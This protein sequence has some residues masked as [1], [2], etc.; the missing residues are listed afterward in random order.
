MGVY[1]NINATHSPGVAPEVTKYFERT[2]LEETEANLVHQRDLQHRVLPLKSGASIQF[3]KFQP[4]NPDDT[5]LKEG[6]TPDGQTLRVTEIHA[7]PKPYGQYVPYTDELDMTLI[8]DNTKEASKLLARQAVETLDL[9]C[10]NAMNG[11][12]NVIFVDATN[13]TNTSRSDIAAGT[14]ILTAASVKRAVRILEKNNAQK[15][16]DGYFHGI[17][18]PETKYDLTSDP[19]WVD[20]A[21][22]QRADK[23]DKYELGMMLGVKFFE[24]TRTKVFKASD[25][26]YVDGST[27]VTNL[28]LNGGAWDVTKQEG[29]LTIAKTTAYAAGTDADY[30]YWCRRMNGK[31]IRVYDAS[32]T[33]YMD[34]LIDRAMVDGSNLKL[35]LRY[36]DT[37]SNF[38][39]ASG[40]KIY[41][42]G[43]GAS[44]CDVHA[45]IIYGENFAGSVTLGSEGGKVQAILKAPG[46]SGSDDP[47]NQRGTVA[48]K[49]NGFCATILQPAYGVRIE[50]SVS[51]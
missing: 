47:L 29:Y 34:A 24:S 2:L 14:D 13:G 36:L 4:F 5:P 48:W 23:I 15:F 16:A 19:L 25:P 9:V 12:D 41:A 11:G 6:V 27:P 3:R 40:D 42:T 38:T 22:Y 39:Y 50:H 7:T 17:I 26:L 45:T 43:G 44:N 35:T 32:A 30:A 46:S 1:D 18:D 31:M 33:A 28:A 51:A 20:V 10:A 49:V 8:D 37:A 21:K